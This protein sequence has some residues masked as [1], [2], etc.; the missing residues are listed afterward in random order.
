MLVYKQTAK[1]ESLWPEPIERVWQTKNGERERPELARE[2]AKKMPQLNLGDIFFLAGIVN[3]E[4]RPHGGAF[5]V[6][7][8]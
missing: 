5:L 7:S 2:L 8:R 3:T 1:A 6:A 4:E